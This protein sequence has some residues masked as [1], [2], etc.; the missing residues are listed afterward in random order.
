M[1]SKCMNPICS[2]PFRYLRDGRLFHL[3]IPTPGTPAGRRLERFWLCA[4]CSSMFTI[5]LKNSAAMLQPRFL[6]LP[7]GERVE[8]SEEEEP[9]VA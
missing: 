1:L 2:T 8:E 6:E 5:V 7:T 3:E 9:F 4:A